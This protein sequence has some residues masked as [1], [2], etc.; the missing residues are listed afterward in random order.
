MESVVF[1]QPFSICNQF[2]EVMCLI[3]VCLTFMCLIVV[4]LT[5]VCLTVVCLTVV[6]LTVVSLIVVFLLVVCLSSPGP[7][8]KRPNM[9]VIRQAASAIKT[10]GVTVS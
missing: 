4:H 5:V 6:S 2:V 3:V 10:P 7:V 9:S 1:P 8:A